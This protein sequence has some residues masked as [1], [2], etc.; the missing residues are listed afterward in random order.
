MMYI[1]I[2]YNVKK[3]MIMNIGHKFTNNEDIEIKKNKRDLPEIFQCQKKADMVW[4]YYILRRR[5]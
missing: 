4:V 3:S 5:Q 1:S 2:M